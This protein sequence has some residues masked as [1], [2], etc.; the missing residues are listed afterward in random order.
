MKDKM[1]KF[2]KTSLFAVY[3]LIF[4]YKSVFKN[5]GLYHF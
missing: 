5:V 3:R 1:Q 2:T 4:M